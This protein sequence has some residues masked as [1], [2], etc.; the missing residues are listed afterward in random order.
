MSDR[1]LKQILEQI[2]PEGRTLS[3]DYDDELVSQARPAVE[4]GY[5]VVRPGWGNDDT[6][7]LTD[8]GRIEI[9]LA[10]KGRWIDRVMHRL[11]G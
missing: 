11:F 7:E 2:G 5:L 8:K 1:T 10:P 3:I 4:G 6:Y 9:G